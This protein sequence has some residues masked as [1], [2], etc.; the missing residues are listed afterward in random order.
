MNFHGFLY[1]GIQMSPSSIHQ[2]TSSDI[3]STFIIR[4]WHVISGKS[5]QRTNLYKIINPLDVPVSS[6]SQ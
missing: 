3:T 1:P 5:F 6:S 2:V 4:S